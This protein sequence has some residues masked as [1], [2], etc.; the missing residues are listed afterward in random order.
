MQTSR[1]RIVQLRTDGIYDTEYVP[2]M[3]GV[4]ASCLGNVSAIIKLN[5]AESESHDCGRA[6]ELQFLAGM[7]SRGYHVL[8]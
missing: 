5:L 7:A 6:V 3:Q 4:S 2:S 8:K 1:G